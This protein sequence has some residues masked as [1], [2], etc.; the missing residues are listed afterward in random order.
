[1]DLSSVPAMDHCRALRSRCQVLACGPALGSRQFELKDRAA[2]CGG[3]DPDAAAM[4]LDDRA[5]DRKPHSHPA[6]LAREKRVEDALSVG[7]TDSRSAVLDRHV[8]RA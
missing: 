8:N 6:R 3:R 4:T 2:A 7:C 1:M 5:A